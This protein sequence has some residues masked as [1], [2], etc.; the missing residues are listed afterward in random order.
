VLEKPEIQT[1]HASNRLIQREAPAEVQVMDRLPTL[2][3]PGLA[4]EE[5]PWFGVAAAGQWIGRRQ[6]RRGEGGAPQRDDAD[7]YCET[8]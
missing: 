7:E 5:H 3:P 6:H 1:Q 2:S 8:S 4:L